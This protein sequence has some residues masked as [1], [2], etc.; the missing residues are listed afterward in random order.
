[1]YK[2]EIWFDGQCIMDR[3]GVDD[4]E[5]ESEEEALEAGY[6]EAEDRIQEWKED[7]AWDGETLA[8]MDIRVKEVN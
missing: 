5:Y 1:M 7:E 3:T 4:M 6:E 8:D 2:Y